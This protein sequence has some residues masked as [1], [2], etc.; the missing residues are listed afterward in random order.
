QRQSAGADMA[1]E[2]ISIK[3]Y[4]QPDGPPPRFLGLDRRRPGFGAQESPALPDPRQEKTNDG[5][6]LEPRRFS[7][8]AAPA[9]GAEEA[10]GQARDPIQ[11]RAQDAGGG[12]EECGD[13]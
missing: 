1:C 12:G 8:P 10:R 2:A 11:W 9:G 3:P 4:A 13:S 5:S 7:G 6:V